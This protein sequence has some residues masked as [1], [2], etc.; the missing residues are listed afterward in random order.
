MKDSFMSF[1]KEAF[2]ILSFDEWNARDK[3]LLINSFV[4]SFANL[5]LDNE[6]L[7]IIKDK[8]Y[9]WYKNKTSYNDK[10]YIVDVLTNLGEEIPQ[11]IMDDYKNCSQ[12]EIEKD[13]S[14]FSDLLNNYKA[15]VSNNECKQWISHL[16]Y[17]KCNVSNNEVNKWLS[18][19]HGLLVSSNKL[20][21][22]RLLVKFFDM[23]EKHLNIDYNFYTITVLIKAANYK[24]YNYTKIVRNIS[25]IYDNL[26][27]KDKRYAEEFLLKS[28]E[29]YL[30]NHATSLRRN[31][32]SPYGLIEEY[33]HNR[34]LCSGILNKLREDKR[35]TAAKKE[36]KDNV[37]SIVWHGNSFRNLYLTTI[38][39]KMPIKPN[40]PFRKFSKSMS[41][42]KEM[43]ENEIK[44]KL[45][46]DELTIGQ[47]K[48]CFIRVLSCSYEINLHHISR[49]IE[50][51][52]MYE[53]I[54]CGDNSFYFHY[55]Y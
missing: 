34:E 2:I 21:V 55:D 48:D 24:S 45:I 46:S 44:D 29:E 40:N 39:D 27:D 10:K 28:S 22:E 33:G 4:R 17:Y 36:I 35:E 14:Q 47:I 38:M 30:D 31:L 42:S 43:I 50:M 7:P 37:G 53:L 20:N 41:G 54:R 15:K 9:A 23:K 3:S 26:G 25:L 16:N 13:K 12:K 19:L 8:L 52:K 49:G 6:L 18:F 5:P 1:M 32:Y 11:S 51:I